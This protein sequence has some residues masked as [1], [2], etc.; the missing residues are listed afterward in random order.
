MKITTL[1]GAVL[2]TLLLAAPELGAQ[3]RQRT[4]QRTQSTNQG[5]GEHQAQTHDQ[6]T[7]DQQ[8]RDPHG[9]NQ[10]QMSP[11]Q[12][13]HMQQYYQAEA[14]HRDRV[15]RL[16]RLRELAQ[17][18]GDTAQLAQIEELYAKE[19]RQYNARMASIRGQLG[20]RADDADRK[21]GRHHDGAAQPT[22]EAQPK[23]RDGHDADGRSDHP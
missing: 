10:H 8:T 6:Q 11:Q 13:A 21:L 18:R 2:A 4:N 12:R 23:T 9:S 19:H 20:D 17:E 14:Q 16:K 3:E 7:R 1:V 15:A 22:R 5:R